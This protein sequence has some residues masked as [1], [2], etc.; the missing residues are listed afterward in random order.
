MI[1]ENTQLFGLLLIR[2]KVHSDSRGTF[3]ESWRESTYKEMGLSF[4]QD[5]QSR[6]KRNVLRGL[7]YQ[8]NIPQG[9]LIWLS[10]GE[11]YDVCVDIRKDSPT[12]GKWQSFILRADNPY[13]V[14]MPSGFAHG[15]CVLSDWATIQYKCTAYY[16]ATDDSGIVWN[17]LE[18]AI[19]WPV[20]SPLIS[21][22]DQQ[23]K[24]F[25]E[26]VITNE[27]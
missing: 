20:V 7:H 6:S 17:D 5:N 26:L 10:E 3:L 22:K 9:Q 23:L 13:Q 16:S 25:K 24:S 21:T 12:F 14:Y 27:L 11:V 4:V 15:F 18:L 8:K 1:I 2:P 19:H